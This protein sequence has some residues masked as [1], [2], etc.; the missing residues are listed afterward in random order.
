MKIDWILGEKEME[1]QERFSYFH[2]F[3]TNI[4]VHFNAVDLDG[5]ESWTENRFDG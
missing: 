3:Y 1:Y 4:W 2:I 5:G